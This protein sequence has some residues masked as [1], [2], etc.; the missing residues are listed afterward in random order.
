MK[1]FTDKEVIENM[2]HHYDCAKNAG[3]EGYGTHRGAGD[4]GRLS[5]NWI[6]WRQEAKRRGLV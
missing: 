5:M 3:K 1:S 6:M 4:C 2:N